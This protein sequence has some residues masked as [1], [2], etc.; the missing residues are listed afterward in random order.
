MRPGGT[1]SGTYLAFET[2]D[3]TSTYGARLATPTKGKGLIGSTDYYF[4]RFYASLSQYT[5]SDRRLKTN[6]RGFDERYEKMFDEMNPCL[7]ELKADLGV[8]H[9][10]MVAQEVEELMK[11]YGIA[12]EEFGFFEH[13]E[14]KDSYGL[15]YSELIPLNTHMLQKTRKELETTKEQLNEALIKINELTKTI[16]QLAN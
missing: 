16:K 10:G 6:F 9:S 4:Y 13:D 14:D 1:S 7:Y 3:N 2:Y 11:K 12:K 15:T 8:S 5:P